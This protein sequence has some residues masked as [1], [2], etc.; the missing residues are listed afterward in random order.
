MCVVAF[1]TTAPLFPIEPV[2]L[3]VIALQSL[4]GMPFTL[5]HA[6][7]FFRHTHD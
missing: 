6:E 7:V 3:L 5:M 1:A 4:G 2:D